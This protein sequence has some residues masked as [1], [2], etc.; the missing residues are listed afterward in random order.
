MV[1]STRWPCRSTSVPSGRQ[2]KPEALRI[3]RASLDRS[4]RPRNRGV[5]PE[6]IARADVA[7]QRDRAA[8]EDQARD[9]LAID[10]A[11]DGA[12]E[13][14]VAEPPLLRR[15]LRQVLAGQ[16]VLVEDQE[17]VFEARARDP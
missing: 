13:V 5:D 14:Q 16:I 1:N 7:P 12:A 15:D 11:R 17:V 4:R 6:A 9:A 2:E 8:L 3:S 10:R